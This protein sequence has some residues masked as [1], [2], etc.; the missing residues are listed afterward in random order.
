TLTLLIWL[1]DT[2]RV[3][4][5]KTLTVFYADTRQELPPLA[6]G[7]WPVCCGMLPSV[8]K[9]AEADLVG[10]F[11]AHAMVEQPTCA[12]E[13]QAIDQALGAWRCYGPVH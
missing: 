1:I 12:D 3:K 6:I 11:A 9:Q 13:H 5:P 2:G 4:A 8:L 10:L 7:I